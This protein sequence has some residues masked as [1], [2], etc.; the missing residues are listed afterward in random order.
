M[1]N[2][3]LRGDNPRYYGETP[4]FSRLRRLPTGWVE[5]NLSQEREEN[6]PS[7]AFVNGLVYAADAKFLIVDYPS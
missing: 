3:A 1:D 2:E 7:R 5:W 6:A 4:A